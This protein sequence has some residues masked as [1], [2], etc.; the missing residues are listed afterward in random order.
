MSFK[1][2][3]VGDCLMCKDNLFYNLGS[4]KENTLQTSAFCACMSSWSDYLTLDMYV[5]MCMS[6]AAQRGT[7][8]QNYLRI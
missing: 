1:M 5:C 7:T 3:N 4:T 6:K 2:D 8:G